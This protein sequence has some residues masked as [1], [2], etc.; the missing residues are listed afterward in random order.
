MPA[1]DSGPPYLGPLL[2]VVF[3]LDGTLVNSAHDFLRMRREVVRLAERHGVPPGHLTVREPIPKILEAA[4]SE[5]TSAGISEGDRFRFEGAVNDAIDA[6]ELEAL[7]RTTARKGAEPLLAS[8]T[9]KGYRLG[10]LTRSSERFCRAAL[11]RTHL[12]T[13][14][15]SLRTRSSPGPAKPSPESLLFLLKEMGV[16]TDRALFVGDHPMDAEC[17]VRARVKFVGILPE[18]STEA[19]LADRLTAAGAITVA[20]DLA[21][22]GGVI[23][24][25]AAPRGAVAR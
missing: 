5:L 16:T 10:I 11:D 2:G 22:L 1:E 9:E 21:K 14:F 3:D 4:L 7:P 13:F 19:D 23:G 6:I 17:A 20:P 15:P 25:R 18:G 8:L 24:I 12:R